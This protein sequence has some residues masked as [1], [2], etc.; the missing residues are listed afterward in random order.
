[1]EWAIVALAAFAL[2]A[3]VRRAMGVAAAAREA[4]H[5]Q[6]SHKER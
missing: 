6:D 3:A 1:M 5:Q 2:I 4:E